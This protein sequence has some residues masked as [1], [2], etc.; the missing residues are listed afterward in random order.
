MN[1]GI[2][3]QF[4]FILDN[5]DKFTIRLTRMISSIFS[6]LT[7]QTNVF[8]SRVVILSFKQIILKKIYM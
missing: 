5:V 8:L 3:C 1:L 4:F 6:S 2:S 7:H